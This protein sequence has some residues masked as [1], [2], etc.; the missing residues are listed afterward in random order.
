MKFNRVLSE[1]LASGRHPRELLKW[2]KIDAVIKDART[3]GVVFEQ[4]GVEVPEQW[5]PRATNIVA[6]K[7]FRK[8]GVPSCTQI[9]EESGLPGFLCRAIPSPDAEFG[10]ETSADQVFRRLAGAW[11]YWGWN[12]S[13]FNEEEDARVFYDEIYLCMAMQIAAPNSPQWFNTGLHWA[14]GIE[15]PDN[16]MWY[17]PEQHGTAEL[18]HAVRTSNSYER[19]QPHAC[20]LT[21]VK[22]HLV[23]EGGI[24]DAWL[25][26]AKIFKFG[27]GSG[28]NASIWRGRGE[29]LSGGGAASGVM[30]W[31]SIGD[32][33][34][35]A[36]QSGGTTRRAAKMVMLDDDHPEL[37][38]FINW[39]VREEH[40][41][42]SMFVGSK[43]IE[44]LANNDLPSAL[45][46]LVPPQVKERIAAGFRP[47]ILGIGWEEEANRTIDGQNSNNS[48]RVSDDFMQCAAD[49]KPWRLVAR[50]TGELA[51]ELNA[52]EV[53]RDLA[54]AAWASADPGLIYDDTVNAWNTCAADGRIR[55]TNPCSE[56][57][58]L[59]GSACNLAS[60]R[61]TAFLLPNG[62]IN[63]NLMVHVYRLWTVV[64]DISVSMASFPAPEFAVGAYNYRTLGLG[65]SDLGGLLMRLGLAYDSDEARALAAVLTAIMTGVAYRTSAELAREL[66]PFPRW[67]VCKSDFMRVMR[68]HRRALV[69]PMDRD[70]EGLNVMPYCCI[71]KDLPKKYDNLVEVAVREWDQV[72]KAESFRNAQTTL[73]A[74]T[75]TISFVMDCD[76][77]GVEP[78]FALVKTKSLAGGGTMEIV[79]PAVLPALER[80]GYDDEAISEIVR[81]FEEHG[82][83]PTPSTYHRFVSYEHMNVFAGANEI[84]PKAHVLMLAAVQPFLSG[85]ASKTVNFKNT[86]TVADVIDVYV[87]AHCMGI[88]ALALY[89]DGSKLSQP[90]TTT[91]NLA[92]QALRAEAPVVPLT[93]SSPDLKRGERE[94]LPWRVGGGYRQKVIIGSQGHE[95]FWRTGDYPDGRMGELWITIA[96]EG[97]TLRSFAECVA[98]AVSIGTQ[99]GVP[100][101]KYVDAFMGVSFEP[102][103]YVEGHAEISF[104]S[105]MMD[106]IARDLAI[107][108]LGRDDLRKNVSHV[109]LSDP[110]R[111]VALDRRAIAVAGG[112]LTGETCGT[113]GGLMRRTG[114]CRTCESCGW[115]DGCV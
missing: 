62:G 37:P 43:I 57:H 34:A 11:T 3:G 2:T 42:A 90:M 67:D 4:L 31:L 60:S 48:V 88:K 47:E 26:E 16:G 13:Y 49:N 101:R 109:A 8:A 98:M 41:A 14:Y 64:L 6:Q 89:R 39:K 76:T 45:A 83:I 56:F 69:W 27:S 70:W 24:M 80:L 18:R 23:K 65:Y 81:Y 15:G 58:H 59:D 52:G 29:L 21:P 94:H 55:T 54:R 28:L 113:C 46:E 9:V 19:P 5:S 25:K 40:K 12:H 35:G 61:Q 84:D 100:L 32:K 63:V 78:E 97:S 99:H 20:F 91:P 104:A 105:S 22:D 36:I 1:G 92:E 7:Y 110:E 107:T 68:N 115:N 38:D 79:N 95:L 33:A 44:M 66:G 93:T 86:A 114:T 53:F 87:L 85:A 72:V 102:S 96:R 108:Y 106:L 74:P 103:G 77:T 111:I 50:T 71:R 75:G 51:A 17:V 30:S 10:R 112:E 73:I 82:A